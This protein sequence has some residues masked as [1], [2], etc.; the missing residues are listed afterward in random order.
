MWFSCKNNDIH[1]R[2]AKKAWRNVGQ[3]MGIC[4]DSGNVGSRGRQS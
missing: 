3:R 2:T 1:A 4:R